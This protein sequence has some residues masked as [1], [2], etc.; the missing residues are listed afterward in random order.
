MPTRSLRS[1]PLQAK[2]NGNRAVA[3][4]PPRFY[5][6]KRVDAHLEKATVL[7]VADLWRR[8]WAVYRAG[9]SL[10]GV[11]GFA[12]R[13][14]AFDT[15]EGR[16]HLVAMQSLNFVSILKGFEGSGGELTLVAAIN[17]RRLKEQKRRQRVCEIFQTPVYIHGDCYRIDADVDASKRLRVSRML[18]VCE[19]SRDPCKVTVLDLGCSDPQPSGI[20]ILDI[21]SIV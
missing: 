14:D 8:A 11:T 19:K 12:L 2:G 6:E 3:S 13:I 5:K 4:A 1:V 16:L 18:D 20:R 17:I 15:D 9:D 10:A 7:E 21:V